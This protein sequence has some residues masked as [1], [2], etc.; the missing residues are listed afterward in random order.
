MPV[1][2]LSRSFASFA[3]NH[4]DSG[5]GKI[6][7]NL[8]E[9]AQGLPIA[10]PMRPALLKTQADTPT[11][12]SPA[13]DRLSTGERELI[14]VFVQMTQTLGLP[15]SFGEIYGLLFASPQPLSQQD[16]MVRLGISKGSVSQG[17]RFLRTIGAI[18][19]ASEASE[20]RECFVPVVELRALVGGFIRERITPQLSE[21]TD[22]THRIRLDD[23]KSETGD[24]SATADLKVI[25]NRLEKL[26]TWHQRAD[27]VLP[28]MGKL[29]G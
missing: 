10:V 11:E 9:L 28:L 16:I 7:S 8:F 4:A 18:Q 24:V 14:A 3:V 17:L 15:R 25:G 12:I 6:D 19:A 20:R 21:W 2:P 26:K 22:R 29:I 23:F 27:L 1:P 13:G 5:E